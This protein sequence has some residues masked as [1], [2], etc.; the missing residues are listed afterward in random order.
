MKAVVLCA[1]YGTR[2]GELT[3][4]TPKAML[5]VAGRPVLEHIVRHLAQHGFDEIAVNLHFRP[6]LI[7]ER[8]GDGAALGVRITYLEEPELLGTAG[9][10]TALRAFL[11]GG[12]FLVQYGDILTDH[13]L[14][15]LA[16]FHLAHDA[17]LT[18]LVHDR[19]G[20]NSV[21]VLDGERR[22]TAF[23]ERPPLDHPAR[24]ESSWV[25]SGLCMCSP[26]LLELLPPPPSDLARDVL[27]GLAGRPDVF[28]QPLAGRRVAVDSPE[29]YRQA[30]M[31][32]ETAWAD[33]TQ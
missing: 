10:L 25:N 17:L 11:Q 30:G 6:E 22:V 28:A 24:R 14:S 21:A 33:A 2:L 15:V 31:S 7:R 4:E 1:G 20:S 27:P 3:R 8:F 23:L 19:P 18:L 12:P 13:D 29:R 16:E 5:P 26:R 9:T 32:W